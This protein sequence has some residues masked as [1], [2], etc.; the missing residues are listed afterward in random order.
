M[1]QENVRLRTLLTD[2]D[3]E[4]AMRVHALDRERQELMAHADSTGDYIE[5]ATV[6]AQEFRAELARRV[7]ARASEWQDYASGL[8]AGRATGPRPADEEPLRFVPVERRI[9]FQN[10]VSIF[11]LYI[12]YSPYVIAAI[13]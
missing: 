12:G 3:R 1:D 5:S 11:S 8:V 13:H 6:H 10:V 4:F 2:S 7:R 9:F